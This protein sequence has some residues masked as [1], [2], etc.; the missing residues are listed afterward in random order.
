MKNFINHDICIFE[1][2]SEIRITTDI[3]NGF[4][5]GKCDL[6]CYSIKHEELKIYKD[7]FN[8]KRV[9]VLEFSNEKFV[10]GIKAYSYI[11]KLINNKQEV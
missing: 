7:N 1:Y 11:Y 5:N 6:G 8:N 10:I 9:T 3:I 4:I 2:N